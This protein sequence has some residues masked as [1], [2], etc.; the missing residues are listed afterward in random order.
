V[1]REARADARTG[2]V[3][4]SEAAP[5]VVQPLPRDPAAQPAAYTAPAR[6][7]SRVATRPA[8]RERGWVETGLYMMALPMALSV[9]F[10]LAPVVAPIFLMF[11]SR[12]RH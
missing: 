7:E 12:P 4:R 9:G 11:G 2:W 1:A 10:M 3:Y 6:V 8:R 5:A